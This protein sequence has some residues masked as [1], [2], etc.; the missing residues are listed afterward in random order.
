MGL[1]LAKQSPSHDDLQDQKFLSL[2]QDAIDLYAL[3]H[4]RYLR[5]P[6]GKKFICVLIILSRFVNRLLKVLA[7]VL[8]PLLASTL[9]QTTSLAIWNE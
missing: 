5:S 6:E 4:A 9:R 8:W 2:N 1:I 3:L 7:D